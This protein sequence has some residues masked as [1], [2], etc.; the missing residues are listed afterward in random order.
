MRVLLARGHH[1][2]YFFGSHCTK[3]LKKVHFQENIITFATHNLQKEII[4]SRIL[5]VNKTLTS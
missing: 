5:H 3:T 2:G 1:H 4:V